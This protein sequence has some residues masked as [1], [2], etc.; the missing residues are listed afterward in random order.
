MSGLISDRFSE[1][2]GQYLLTSVPGTVY[3]IPNFITKDEVLELLERVYNAPKPKWKN[4]SNRRLQNWGGLPHPKG[5]S[6]VHRYIQ[7]LDRFAL[8]VFHTFIPIKSSWHE[9]PV[10]S[11]EIYTPH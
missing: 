5:S 9:S 6:L 8:D 7:H 10:I 11:N 1:K 3:Y 4:L 2:Y